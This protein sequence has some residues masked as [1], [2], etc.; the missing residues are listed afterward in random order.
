[1]KIFGDC[2]LK[3]N[4][5]VTAAEIASSVASFFKGIT[6][7]QVFRKSSVTDASHNFEGQLWLCIEEG[8]YNLYSVRTFFQI[9]QNAS[10]KLVTIRR[11]CIFGGF[12]SKQKVSIP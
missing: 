4:R 8:F 10:L 7:N 9:T 5:N 11:N 12:L 1:M 2:R 3:L 6:I